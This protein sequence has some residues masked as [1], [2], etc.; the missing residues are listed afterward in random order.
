MAEARRAMLRGC[1]MENTEQART[2]REYLAAEDWAAL[3]R[4]FESLPVQDIAAALAEVDEAEEAVELFRQLDSEQRPQV[5]SYLT[6]AFQ[7]GLLESLSN[8]EARFLLANIFPD[9]LTALLE[10]LP[11]ETLEQTLKLLSADTV[12]QVIRLLGYPEES[13]GRLMTPHFVSVRP[14]WSIEQALAHI[15]E[16]SEKGETVNVIFVTDAGGRLLDAVKLKRF[17]L[18]PPEKRV[19][20]L[21]AEQAISVPAWEDREEVVRQMQHYDLE[22]MPVVDKHNVLLGIVTID[23]VMDV[24]EEETTEDFQKMGGVGVLNLSLRDARASLLYRKRVGWLV[25]LVFVNIFSGAAIAYFEATI[26]AVIALVFFLPMLVASAGNAGAQAST[27]M[28][29]ALATGDVTAA[30][31][32]R[33]WGKELAVSGALGITMGVAVSLIGLWRG[34]PEVGLVVA[35]SMFCVVVMGSM[36]GMLLPIVLARFKLDPATASAPLVTTV[37]DIFGITIYFSI[38]TAIL[39][40]TPP[41]G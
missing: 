18:T 20:T 1:A 25:L 16:E 39:G 36:L 19:D 3:R 27:L 35:L 7:A 17:I 24:A 10:R 41:G 2:L 30:D 40:V 38:A 31:W 28:V 23:D 29:R 14:D 12:K 13:A 9:D 21:I 4:H 22:A 15:R 32:L 37:A 5:F 26:E 33:L 6:P 34:G 11:H 8:Q